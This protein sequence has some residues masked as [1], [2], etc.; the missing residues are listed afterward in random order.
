MK[1]Q[2]H[3]R[4]LITLFLLIAPLLASARTYVLV[5]GAF[6]DA[7][8]WQGVTTALEQQ[9][10]RVI[11][12]NL[13]GHG[14]DQTPL[15][16]I[17]FDLYR[18]KISQLVMAQPEPV[19][20]VGHS[21]AGLLISAVAEQLPQKISRLVF[22]GAFIPQSGDAVL[23]LNGR[24]GQSQFGKNLIMAADQRSATMQPTEIA[25]VFC[26]DCTDEQ[27]KQLAATHRPEPTGPLG[28]KVILTAERFGRVPKQMIQTVRDQ[29][30]GIQLQEQMTATAST[31]KYVDRLE[32]GHL[33]F[34]SQPAALTTLLVKP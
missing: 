27:K 7:S 8:A 21:M 31:V 2:F 14:S 11:A 30:I 22:V 25:N 24:D 5:H 34:L 33:P 1:S 26:A 28:T 12:I 15:T 6:V 10:H 4:K 16:T 9:G 19:V 23:S 17:T 32:T 3:I 18:D 20:L 29:A 13:P